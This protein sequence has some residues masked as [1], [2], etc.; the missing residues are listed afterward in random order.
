MP[1]CWIELVNPVAGN[2]WRF[3]HLPQAPW[4]ISEPQYPVG[5]HCHVV[6]RVE[7]LAIEL[8]RHH[9]DTAVGLRSNDVAGTVLTR[10]EPALK[11]EDVAIG[12]VALAKDGQAV[13]FVPLHKL[14]VGNVGKNKL[15]LI[16]QPH[17]AFGELHAAGELL[18]LCAGRNQ[19][20]MI[21]SIGGACCQEYH[22][23]KSD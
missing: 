2:L 1:G 21:I 19:R 5:S 4:G 9:S 23:R 20:R 8:L 3:V 15:L 16:R 7:P 12:V 14:A 17:R 18:H 6:G 22:E 11:I 13:C 10:D